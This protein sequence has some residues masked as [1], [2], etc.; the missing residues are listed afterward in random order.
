MSTVLFRLPQAYSYTLSGA[1]CAV[2]SLHIAGL[3]FAAVRMVTFNKATMES[4]RREFSTT[5]GIS[6]ET[7][8]VPNQGYPDDGNG[9]FAKSLDYYYWVV[10]NRAAR[11]YLNSTEQ[12]ANF[13]LSILLCGIF[14]PVW[15]GWLGLLIGAARVIYYL[16]YAHLGVAVMM[17]GEVLAMF[18]MFFN[19]GVFFYYL[20]TG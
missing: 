1:A 10:F 4:L 6:D 20:I 3:L 15:A 9:R 16:G 17:I 12:I 2:A 19:Y 13:V 11:G 5:S 18:P 7:E 8:A 14:Q